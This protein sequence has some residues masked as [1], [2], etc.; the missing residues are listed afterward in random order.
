[1]ELVLN[2]SLESLPEPIEVSHFTT[3]GLLNSNYKSV[4]RKNF[5]QPSSASVFGIRQRLKASQLNMVNHTAVIL[6]L[7]VFAIALIALF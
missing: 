1:M 6:K 7:S 2:T 4:V 5:S 3:D